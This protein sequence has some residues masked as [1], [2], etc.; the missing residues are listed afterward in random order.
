MCKCSSIVSPA[1]DSSEVIHQLSPVVILLTSAKRCSSF[2]C[3]IPLKG[4][5]LL[6][7]KVAMEGLYY[8][9]SVHFMHDHGKLKKSKV[10]FDTF[11]KPTEPS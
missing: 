1:L 2:S 6:C 7:L 3:S 4:S 9:A 10:K 11:T 5:L 8:S